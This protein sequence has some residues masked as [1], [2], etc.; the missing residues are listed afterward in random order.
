MSRHGSGCYTHDVKPRTLL[1]VL[2]ALLFLS[3]TPGFSQSLRSWEK[4]G[5]LRT[6][7]FD[8]FYAP[9]LAAEALRL[10]GFADEVLRRQ[11]VQDDLA[12]GLR[13]GQDVLGGCGRARHGRSLCGRVPRPV[14][15]VRRLQVEAQGRGSSV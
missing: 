4:A 15:C 7:R 1:N 5:H 9:S 2:I 3:T 14:E 11:D 10:A 13:G 6:Q 12:S 8:I